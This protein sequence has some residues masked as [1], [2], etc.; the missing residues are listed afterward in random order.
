MLGSALEPEIR[1]LLV[2][3]DFTTLKGALRE[4]EPPD[5]AELLEEF[6]GEDQA[7][8]FRLLGREKAA[9]VFSLLAIETQEDLIARL[10]QASVAHI[11]NEMTPD[12]RT[13]LLEE[14]PGE[15][16]QR[17]MTSLRG[18]E[19][20]IARTLLN[21]PPD[22]VGRIMTPEFVAVRPDW[23]VEKLLEH[24]RNVAAL[25]ETVHHLYVVDEHSRL[26]DH[27]GLEEVVL[28]P[29]GSKV[30]DLMSGP[31]EE[32]A[33]QAHW[34][35]QD[36][37]EVFKKYDMGAL[38]VVNSQ[39]VLVGLVTSDDM[40]DLQE[41]IDTEDIQRLAAVAPMESSYLHTSSLKMMGKRL[42]WLVFLLFAELLT[43][44]A[45]ASFET[46]FQENLVLFVLFMPLL[47]ATAG[48]VGSQMAALIVRGMA[49]QEVDVEDWLPVCL[50]ELALGLGMGSVLA[51]LAYGTALLF[52]RP[53]FVGFALA[54]AMVAAITVAN[55][56]GA[57]IPFLL[58]RLRFDPAVTS[59]PLI[60]S[61]MDVLSV[62][63]YFSIAL[64]SLR[65][66]G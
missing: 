29:P 34:P 4:L 35:Q 10:S 40:L 48:N 23:T 52:G 7:L 27:I 44:L 42:P 37:V 21:Y 55:L 63:I 20:A 16:A 25:K 51:A 62:V 22:S 61:L 11:L 31:T 12:D 15:L 36:A 45:I 59:T 28:A 66:F 39:G 50:R 9:E 1:E 17:L 24:I 18:D 43:A 32:P 54:L 3:K 8:L 46:V 57:L 38:P 13:E 26:L 2:R 41:E 64:A 53:W 33:L 47:N 30:A 65:A 14:L 5:I 6:E 58:K 19:L 60:A 49:L 56:A